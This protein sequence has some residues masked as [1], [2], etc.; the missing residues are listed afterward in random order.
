MKRIA[1]LQ[2]NYLPWKGYFDL[3][4]RVDEFVFYDEV[5]YTTSD[6]RN[7]NRI[8]TAQGLRWLTV[9]VRHASRAGTCIDDV[10][11]AGTRWSTIHARTLHGAYARAPHGAAMIALL[12]PL[13]EPGRHTRL[14]A[15]NRAAIASICRHLGIDT[16]L[17][18]SIDYPSSG[19]GRTERLVEICR[20]AGADCYVSGPAAR[21]YLDE[22]AFAAAGIAVEWFDY[23]GYPEYPQLWGAFEHRVSIVDLL[24]HCG[25]QSPRFLR[26]AR[27]DR[28]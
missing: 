1:I 5:Q 19:A 4:A 26:H 7:R 15:L 3:I 27:I 9:P 23:E 16:T 28:P 14:A 18:R 21:A 6:W 11:I 8:K 25:P 17:S 13:Y 2:S 24:A 12:A 22:A 10:E 20:Q